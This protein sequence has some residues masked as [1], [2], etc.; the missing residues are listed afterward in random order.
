[1]AGRALAF[2]RRKYFRYKAR[3]SRSQ[4]KNTLSEEAGLTISDKE[5][6]IYKSAVKIIIAGDLILLKDAVS[7]A[8][9]GSEYNFTSTFEYT[10]K[11]IS[12]ADLA[13]GVFEG[14]CAGEDTG[15]SSS[16]RDD[17]IPLALNFPDSFAKA[18]KVAG[19]GL[20]STANNHV[21]DKGVDGAL[22]T[23]DVLDAIG[24]THIGSYRSQADKEQ[25]KIIEIKGV[26]FAFLAYT[27][28]SNK[29]KIEKLRKSE[30]SYIS[31]FL[32]DPSSA[33]FRSAKADVLNDFER[34]KKEKPD[35]IVVLP[36]MGSEFIRKPDYYQKAWNKV[37]IEAGADIVLTDHSH[38]VQ[39]IE[40]RGDALIVNGVGN[41]CCSYTKNNGD[42]SSLLE[43]YID[44]N[45]KKV[46]GV[47]IIP[48]YT[49]AP[50]GRTYRA[51]PIYDI[52]TDPDLREQISVY[53]YERIKEVHELITS[54][55]LGCKLPIDMA[56][57]RYYKTKD[58][59]FQDV[60]SPPPIIEQ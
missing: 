2:L 18:V 41:F 16:N 48:L 46:R 30:N 17:G 28:G 5:I 11:Y 24:L 1:M 36:H 45:N 21:L 51:L 25:I 32:A 52:L 19:F 43:I 54:V 13:I 10:K 53:E 14:P 37:F 3:S 56:M 58:G 49:Q 6:D 40:F 33:Q 59:F 34:A 7:N 20:V 60:L 47:S 50:L 12:D 31:S 8:Y 35:V 55:M 38:H 42:A 9:D 15:Y 4:T 39:P 57:S 26:R 23:L 44:Q 29:I 22:R 27:Y